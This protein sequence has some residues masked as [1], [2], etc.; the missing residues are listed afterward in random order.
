VRAQLSGACGPLA[1]PWRVVPILAY[2][3]GARPR[4]LTTQDAGIPSYGALVL[5]NN[6]EAA[7]LFETHQFLSYSLRR[8]GYT[9]LAENR[10]WKIWTR[11]AA[12]P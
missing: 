8:H 2:D 5:P 11:C 7:R 1:A 9:P 3:I 10:S 6:G 4:G 12:A